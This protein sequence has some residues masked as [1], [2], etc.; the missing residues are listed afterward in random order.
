VSRHQVNK[1]MRET[2]LDERQCARFLEDPHAYLAGRDLT[3]EEAEALAQ[4]DC[5]RLYALGAHPF[6]LTGF[7]RRIAPGDPNE[8]SRHYH[9]AIAEFGYPDYST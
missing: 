4:R 9:A 2:A 8:A 6:L 1:I 5:V 7:V 3:P